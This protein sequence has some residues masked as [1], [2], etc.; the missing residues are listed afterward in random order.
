MIIAICENIRYEIYA[1]G[2]SEEEAKAIL[3]SLVS[4]YLKGS[5]QDMN[6]KE[7]EDH[8]GCVLIDTEKKP[9]G[10]LKI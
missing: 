3:W 8:F 6:H 7:L 1:T 9:H 10:F 2:E 5:W 4:D